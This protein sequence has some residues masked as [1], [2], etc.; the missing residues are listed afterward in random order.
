M[1]RLII[2]EMAMLIAGLSFGQTFGQL[3]DG[4]LKFEAVDIR[5]TPAAAPG[6]NSQNMRGG[7]YRGGRYEVRSATMVDLVRTAYNVDADHVTGGPAWMDKDRFDIIAKAPGD[8]T[9]EKMRVMLQ[10][11]L[12]ERFSLVV[13][14]D[15]KPLAAYAIRRGEKVLM[16]RSAGS[17]T[18]GCKLIP[19]LEPPQGA[20]TAPGALTTYACHNVSMAELA[21][22]LRN[23]ILATTPGYA[24]TR[25]LNGYPVV[26]QTELKGGW[27]FD[28]KYSPEVVTLFAAFEKQLGLK[29]ELTKIPMPAIAIDSVN[30]N[31]TPNLND[32][33]TGAAAKMPAPPPLEFEV[34]D[35][36]P[37]DPNPPQGPA[38]G[39]CFYCPGGRLHISR[40]TMSDLI[41]TAWNLNG[42]YDSRVIGLP[43]SLEKVNWDIIARVS[44]MTPVNAPANGI[45]NGQP[46]GQQM[47]F[48]SVRIM[49]QALLKD[50]FKL[51]VH[52]EMRQ[53]N[54]Y[55]LVAVRPKLKPADPD[56]R[57]GCKEGPG[58]DGKDP[59]T[60]NPQ[61][62]RLLTCLSMTVAEFAAELPNRAGDYFAQY[63]GKVVDAT[64]LEGTYDFTLNFSPLGIATGGGAANGAPG[65][66]T[67]YPISLQEAIEKQLGLR[68]EPQKNPAT[69]LV[70]D[71]IEEKPTE[72]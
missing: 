7:L 21:D 24:P 71:H 33:P 1:K 28:I 54:G 63:P 32:D 44:T 9:P 65:E 60:T 52:Q 22:Q 13:H 26:D 61:A 23:M 31:P 51:T 42:N 47:D 38:G 30:E 10:N 48:D 16:K 3:G 43:K 11:L 35:I 69:V 62:R 64:R 37:S 41:A 70:V 56:H 12:A 68:M 67:G 17:D 59:R 18:P 2:A 57:P 53:F 49:L 4:T 5:P 6:T 55:A 15:T 19:P 39:D 25:A 29:L 8:S 66:A 46:P 14:N 40:F 34:A 72:N 50:R 36:R 45:G 20:P 58:P 27:D